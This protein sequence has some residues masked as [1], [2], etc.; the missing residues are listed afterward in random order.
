MGLSALSEFLGAHSRA[1]RVCRRWSSTGWWNKLLPRLCCMARQLL[2]HSLGL[3]DEVSWQEKLGVNELMVSC[4]CIIRV[5]FYFF[6]LFSA[7]YHCLSLS[8]KFLQHSAVV[9]VLGPYRAST[10]AEF[11]LDSWPAAKLVIQAMRITSLFPWSDH[12]GINQSI[13]IMR[14]L[15]ELMIEFSYSNFN[16]HAF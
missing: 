4:C 15:Y 7:F 5:E 1:R 9:P 10:R 11:E 12:R 2:E 8:L 3:S 6:I 13:Y 16:S 14:Q